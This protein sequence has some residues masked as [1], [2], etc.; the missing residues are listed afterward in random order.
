M[1]MHN[2]R[3]TSL[4]PVFRRTRRVMH[5]D[6]IEALREFSRRLQGTH[7]IV[8]QLQDPRGNLLSANSRGH[9][10]HP[11][12]LDA[13][14]WKWAA[15]VS[16]FIIAQTQKRAMP[17]HHA[18]YQHPWNPNCVRCGYPYTSFTGW[19]HWTWS[20]QLNWCGWQFQCWYCEDSWRCVE[21]CE[22]WVSETE[23][24]ASF[25]PVGSSHPT[26]DGE[27]P[28]IGLVEGFDTRVPHQWPEVY[29]RMPC[30]HASYQ[31]PWTPL[32]IRC[33]YP[34]TSI[35]AWIHWTWSNQLNC[36]GWQFQCWY[37]EVDW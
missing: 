4:D 28:W 1:S 20:N 31:H 10:H 17:C 34:Y 29:A 11:M 15:L 13:V 3:S 8:P 14:A 27:N 26:W 5:V 24:V 7:Y 2:R 30:H 6:P 21:N 16:A 19:I 22:D 12:H 35:P 33:G 23:S 37:C 36:R 25:S 18:S 32:C 9:I